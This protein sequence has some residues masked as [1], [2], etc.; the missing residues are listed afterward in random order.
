MKRFSDNT[1]YKALLALALCAPLNAQA[2][3]VNTISFDQV[4]YNVA[5]GAYI[6]GASGKIIWGSNPGYTSSFDTVHLYK[7]II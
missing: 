5:G 1:L 4:P 3:P 6:K 2:A 7:E